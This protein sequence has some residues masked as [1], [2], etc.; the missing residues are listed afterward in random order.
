[1]FYRPYLTNYSPTKKAKVPP[2][3]D[4][5][6]KQAK[7]AGATHL[8]PDGQEAYRMRYGLLERTYAD[9]NWASWWVGTETKIPEG[10][11][12]L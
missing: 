11:T 3:P 10:A 12:S 5:V 4:S 8:S 2:I 1:M 7:Q 9:Q 6:R